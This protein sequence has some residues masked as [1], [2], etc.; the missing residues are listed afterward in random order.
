M[1]VLVSSHLSRPEDF[2]EIARLGLIDIVEVSTEPQLVKETRRAWAIRVPASPD[3]FSIV[4]V[5]NDQTL[6]RGVIQSKLTAFA[7]SFDRPDKDQIRRARTETRPRG[8]DK[9]F[10]RLKMCRRLQA[11]LCKMRNRVTTT[12]RHL[13]HLL[14]NEVVAVAGE[15]EL[16]RDSNKCREEAYTEL[17]HRWISKHRNMISQR[18]AQQGTTAG[19]PSLLECVRVVTGRVLN[20]LH[21]ALHKNEWRWE[22]FY[23]V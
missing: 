18:L 6:K 16:R 20:E 21:A 1:S 15:R 23:P 7:Q 5:A 19:K 3:A 11:N 22:R 10:S 9:E 12:F 17:V 2:H 8:N 14:Q 4:L 13:P